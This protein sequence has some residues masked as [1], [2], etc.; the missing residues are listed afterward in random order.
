MESEAII[1]RDNACIIKV[2][3]SLNTQNIYLLV[4]LKDS[5]FK[6][7]EKILRY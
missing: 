3:R 6:K 7:D 1:V 4:Q 5:Q 2:N